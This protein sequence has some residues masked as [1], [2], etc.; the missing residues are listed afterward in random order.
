MN[1][2]LDGLS[3]IVGSII[4]TSTYGCFGMRYSFVFSVSITLLGAIGLLV[5][6]EG[7]L[8]PH[9]MHY[10]IVNQSPYE[11]DTPEDREYYLAY[12]IPI[13]VFITKA[14]NSITF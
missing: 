12:L 8:S 10:F 11:R 14:G 6:Q 1:Y 5:F 4:S 2:Y 9:F 3:G 13:I 7:Y